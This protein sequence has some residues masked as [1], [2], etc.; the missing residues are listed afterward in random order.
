MAQITTLMKRVADLEKENEQ[1]SEQLRNTGTQGLVKASEDAPPRPQLSLSLPTEF[2]K[3]HDDMQF[4]VE[5]QAAL[6]QLEAA[7]PSPRG[8]VQVQVEVEVEVEVEAAAAAAAAAAAPEDDLSFLDSVSAPSVH[9][10]LQL[11][12]RFSF[13]FGASPRLFSPRDLLAANHGTDNNM[14]RERSDSLADTL[15]QLES[16]QQRPKVS[17]SR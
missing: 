10:M 1:L 9:D 12:P 2:I 11:T 4:D 14:K 5:L 8:E 3:L 15:Q 6:E 13:P 7:V 17:T 16:A